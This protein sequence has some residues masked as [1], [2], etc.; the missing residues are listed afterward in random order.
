[1][2][3]SWPWWIWVI[4]CLSGLGLITLEGA[5]R[6]ICQKEEEFKNQI[7]I[8]KSE[9]DLLRQEH[10]KE[11]FISLK[12]ACENLKEELDRI[13]GYSLGRT[14]ESLRPHEQLVYLS[15]YFVEVDD[16]YGK[17]S[18]SSFTDW[19]KI[20]K[21][22][23]TLGEI[24][25]EGELVLYG[26]GNYVGKEP[27]YIDLAFKKKNLSENIEKIRRSIFIPLKEAVQQLYIEC[28]RRPLCNSFLK[29]HIMSEFTSPNDVWDY[30]AELY[31]QCTSIP[32]Y[33]KDTY[34]NELREIDK[35]CI[36]NMY[37]EDEVS[38]LY[39]LIGKKQQYTELSI[40]RD[41][42]E[43]AIKEIIVAAEG[44]YQSK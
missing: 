33:G 30:L 15:K 1:M 41:E 7:D 23:L 6:L 19:E 20:S 40:R 12:E 14:L 4:I 3:P 9:L 28:E 18:S 44:I 21:D 17:R 39:I 42:V 2:I 10:N 13:Y 8:M 37:F 34:S 5:Y 32:I 11:D 24:K 16:I 25:V 22:K 38:S 36:G 27:D 43:R 35:S 29:E 26:A 31:F